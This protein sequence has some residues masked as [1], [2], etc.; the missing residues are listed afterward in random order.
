MG[1]K[2]YNMDDEQLLKDTTREMVEEELEDM[3][4]GIPSA[5]WESLS[6]DVIA[7]VTDK[8]IAE[9]EHIDIEQEEKE[10][11]MYLALSHYIK[12]KEGV[13]KRSTTPNYDI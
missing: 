3:F 13:A 5:D 12:A 6:Y 2:W 4:L 7:E 11:L 9:A 10:Y 8:Y 1:Q